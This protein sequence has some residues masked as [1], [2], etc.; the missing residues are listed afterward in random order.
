MLFLGK[1]QDSSKVAIGPHGGPIKA[2]NNYKIEMVNSEKF[3][4]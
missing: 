1:A 4:R 2:D 3:G